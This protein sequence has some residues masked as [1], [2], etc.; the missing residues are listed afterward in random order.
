MSSLI[1]DKMENE[2][3]S[4]GYKKVRQ[5]IYDKP[6][7][8]QI[9]RIQVSTEYS[10]EY[11]NYVQFRISCFSKMKGDYIDDSY[12][13]SYDFEASEEAG[14]GDELIRIM[15][16]ESSSHIIPH[17]FLEAY[18]LTSRYLDEKLFSKWPS[19]F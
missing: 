10:K 1:T 5:N 12:T 7:G 17:H 3:A 11:D 19:K 4:L 18:P 13:E 15:R 14:L 6:V 9:F 16:F 8:Y 2:L